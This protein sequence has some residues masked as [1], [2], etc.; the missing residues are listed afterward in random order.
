MVSTSA[1]GSANAASHQYAPRLLRFSRSHSSSRVI[2]ARTFWN[3]SPPSAAVRA[4]G[5][6]GGYGAA[7]SSK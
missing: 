4:D 1:A 2:S 5:L 3:G 6:G 7:S